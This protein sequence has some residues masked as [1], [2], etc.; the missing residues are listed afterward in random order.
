MY[1]TNLTTLIL[2][3]DY[4]PKLGDTLQAFYQQS[5][6]LET[7]VVKLPDLDDVL[8][9]LPRN[10]HS[11]IQSL[12]IQLSDTDL[13][14]RSEMDKDNTLRSEL[15]TMVQLLG[16]PIFNR[17]TRFTIHLDQDF[18][19]RRITPLNQTLVASMLKPLH[20]QPDAYDRTAFY[21]LSD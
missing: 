12:H 19:G 17:L 5:K 13:L 20:F 16:Q 15:E 3:G 4:H 6:R 8:N 10:G 7:L 21:R 2:E 9:V 1:L 14:A 18:K 11:T